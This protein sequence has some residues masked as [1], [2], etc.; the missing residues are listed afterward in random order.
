MSEFK[1]AQL[2]EDDDISVEEINDLCDKVDKFIES[3]GNPKMNI[4]WLANLILR[5]LMNDRDYFVNI[6]GIKGTGKSNFILLLML[7]QT[8]YSGL[9]RNKKTGK[10]VKVLPR[11]KPLK[12]P[13]EHI[14]YGFSFKNNMSFLDDAETVK[15]KFNNLDRYHPFVVDEGS[16][17]L[18]KTRWQDKLQFLLVKMS[19]TER[20]QNKSV[21]VCFPNFKELNSTFRN[22]RIMMRIYLYDRNAKEHYAS[23]I[24]SL[25]DIN[26]HTDDPW[27][28]EDNAQKF[29]QLLK[30][31][32]MAV[33][34]P[35]HV[36]YAEKKLFG[37][38]GNF[39]VP[40]LEYLAPRIWDIYMKYKIYYAQKDQQIEISDSEKESNKIK[41]IKIQMY[42][43]ISYIK[44]KFPEM[45]MKELSNIFDMPYNSFLKLCSQFE[46]EPQPTQQPN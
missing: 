20:Y 3:R 42:N 28:T 27:H 29:E 9:W 40:S 30:R 33:R 11:L 46:K 23:A 45:K 6:E 44:Q 19:D 43:G 2:P 36:L 16:K 21:F 35:S 26:R 12:E 17:V 8:R 18:H 13:W 25:R 41:K 31:V 22:D 24:I 1:Q 32:P 7:L 15:T 39:D 10:I 38:G 4:V 37:Y 5:R 34:G 14:K